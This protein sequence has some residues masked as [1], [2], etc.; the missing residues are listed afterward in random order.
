MNKCFSE[1][2]IFSD[3]KQKHHHW[4]EV[5]LADNR[6]LLPG[7]QF[8]Y[9]TDL[10]PFHRCGRSRVCCRVSHLQTWMPKAW[11]WK[12]LTSIDWRLASTSRRGRGSRTTSQCSRAAGEIRVPPLTSF[13]EH[14]WT[15]TKLCEQ[16]LWNP[17]VGYLASIPSNCT[18][19]GSNE[20]SER[21]FLW[22]YAAWHWCVPFK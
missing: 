20:T 3:L 22:E 12:R 5:S 11:S 2:Q 21:V 16:H 19:L 4:R 18:W 6:P 13:G 10:P 17:L 7:G 1:T 14:L 15:W 9:N 8:R